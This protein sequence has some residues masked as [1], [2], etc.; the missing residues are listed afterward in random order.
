[1]WLWL[2]LWHRLA[3]AA[4]API[5]P[6]TWERPYAVGTALKRK[7]KVHATQIF[8]TRHAPNFFLPSNICCFSFAFLKLFSSF[9]KQAFT[10]PY[11][12]RIG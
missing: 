7:K 3:A 11:L 10:K 1:M 2:W 4:A 8:Y 5:Q 12:I 6:L 9:F